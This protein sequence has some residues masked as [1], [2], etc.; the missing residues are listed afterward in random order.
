MEYCSNIDLFS[1]N[2]H[3]EVHVPYLYLFIKCVTK[4]CDSLDCRLCN[5][6]LCQL[7]SSFGVA[8]PIGSLVACKQHKGSGKNA[9]LHMLV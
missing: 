2:E 4:S 8:M 6:I 5:S 3:S 1:F 9:D 7:A